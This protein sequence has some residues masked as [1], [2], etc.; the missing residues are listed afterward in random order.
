[1][2]DRSRERTAAALTVLR[3]GSTAGSVGNVAYVVYVIAVFAVVYGFPYGR[4][5]FAALGADRM[6]E[7]A[8]DPVTIVVLVLAYGGL[9]VLAHRGG[10]V[11]GPVSPPPIWCAHVLTAPVDRAVAL[12]RWWWLALG[13]LLGAG[14]VLGVVLGLSLWSAGITGWLGVPLAAAVVAAAAGVVALVWLRAQGASQPPFEDDRSWRPRAVLRRLGVE[15]LLAQSGR[16]ELL[17]AGALSGSS[18]TIRAQTSGPV[19]AKG[20]LRPGPCVVLRRDLL[21]LRRSGPGWAA[22]FAVVVAG[23]WVLARAVVADLPALGAIGAAIVY[24]GATAWGRPLRLQAARSGAPALLGWSPAGQAV[25]HLALPAILLAVCL[26]AGALLTGDLT[27]LV[28]LS[29]VPVVLGALCWSAFRPPPRLTTVM[30]Q[31]VVPGVVLW[32]LA[33]VLL[34]GLLTGLALWRLGG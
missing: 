31:S 5:I 23:G 1:M 30:P 33:P 22:P 9:L 32:W 2:T 4:T 14:A 20:A 11:S 21:A 12:R 6:A 3:R 26:A 16:R 34:V 15:S 29:L 13:G 18:E 8:A 17:A 10:R 25:R 27:G 24:V 19:R 7:L 28:G